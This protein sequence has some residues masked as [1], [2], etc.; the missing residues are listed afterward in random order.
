MAR[1][2]CR[3]HLIGES[4]EDR[5]TPTISFGNVY[6]GEAYGTTGM[7]VA[8]GDLTGNGTQDMVIGTAMGIV[9][10]MNYGNGRFFGGDIN[11]GVT[12]NF[13]KLADMTGDGNLDLV[14][15]STDEILIYLGDGNGNFQTQNPIVEKL[16]YNIQDMTISDLN[17]D[18]LPDV[19]AAIPGGAAVLINNGTSTIL[20]SPTYYNPSIQPGQS[21]VA[22]GDFSGNGRPD[23]AVSVYSQDVVD[24]Y[25]NNGNGTFGT[26]TILP[27]PTQ[28]PPT[29][30]VTGD[31]NNDGNIDLVVGFDADS[32]IAL[33]EGN[34]NGTFQS[35]S[36]IQTTAS[37]GLIAAADFDADGNLDLVEADTPE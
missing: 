8:V 19:V 33:Y 12:P 27:D 20:D 30:L 35:P 34:G 13:L 18:G 29:H 16:S 10:D 17:G 4:L 7:S 25:P 1:Q 26:P 9:I 3:K 11:L 2:A 24:I 6:G 37:S 28:S 14:V 36:L 23:I 31:F 5:I 21:Y 32:Q 22:V 15:G